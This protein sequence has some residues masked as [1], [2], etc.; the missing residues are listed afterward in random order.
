MQN[1]KI[2]LAVLSALVASALLITLVA[3]AAPMGFPFVLGTGEIKPSVAIDADGTQHYVWWNSSTQRIRYSACTG[4]DGLNCTEPVNLPAKGASYYPNIA[5]DPEGRPNVVFESKYSGS[6]QVFWTRKD[7]SGWISPV[8]VSNQPYSELPDIAIGPKGIIHIVY[9]SK[10]DTTGYV[11]YAE[12]NWNAWSAPAILAQKRSD[13]PLAVLAE[14]AGQE[15][16][17]EDGGQIST[18]LFPRITVDANDHAHVVWNTP[19]PYSIR[20]RFQTSTGWS[21]RRLV[22]KG[23]K[24]QTPDIAVAP[25]G[26]VGIIW[27]TY[28]DFN[29][30]FAEYQNGRKDKYVRDI[31]HGLAQSLWPRITT[32]CAGKFQFVFQG[33]P[34]PSASWNIYYRGY[35]PVKNKLTKRK[36]IVALGSQEQTPAIAAGTATA[37]VWANTSYRTIY[38]SVLPTICH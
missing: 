14:M 24:D 27:G 34:T 22:A 23:Q 4:E 37:V 9:Q 18:G 35:D 3:A 29:A 1:R 8:Q 7:S 11:Y 13:K 33:K 19:S 21:K 12:N 26:S 30:A 36:T 5:I 25:N 38:G 2:S 20:Y 10:Q 31:D 15:A 16:N 32:D 6:Y 28:D 17:P